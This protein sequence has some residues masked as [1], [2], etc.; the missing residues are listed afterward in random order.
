MVKTFD[1]NGKIT[2]SFDPESREFADRVFSALSAMDKQ[3]KRLLKRN[4]VSPASTYRMFSEANIEIRRKI[5]A[6][7]NAPACDALFGD[8]AVY[9]LSDGTPLWFN[10]MESIIR[11]INTPPTKHCAKIIK[12]YTANRRGK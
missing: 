4:Q 12:S 7:L 2:V 10:L 9:A 1:I 3:Q 8:N 5:D 6:L 11:C